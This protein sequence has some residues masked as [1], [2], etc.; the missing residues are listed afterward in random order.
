MRA[1]TRQSYER[2]TLSSCAN[3]VTMKPSLGK[4]VNILNPVA[5][6]GPSDAPTF[7]T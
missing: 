6:T 5:L 3:F 4:Y 2:E 1:S 7:A